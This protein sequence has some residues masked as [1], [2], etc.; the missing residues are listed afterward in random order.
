MRTLNL[1]MKCLAFFDRV[2]T[3]L[4]STYWCIEQF[5]KI[6]IRYLVGHIGIRK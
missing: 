5:V 1:K 4:G 2:T 6:I 3:I